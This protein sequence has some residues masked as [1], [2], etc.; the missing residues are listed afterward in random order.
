MYQSC[1]RPICTPTAR[2]GGRSATRLP[3]Y[4]PPD[5]NPPSPATVHGPSTESAIA[6][7]GSPSRNDLQHSHRA[8]CRYTALHTPM[9]DRSS[10]KQWRP[11]SKRRQARFVGSP[12]CTMHPPLPSALPKSAP[13]L[14]DSA[15]ETRLPRRSFVASSV[16]VRG[17]L[18]IGGCALNPIG[19]PAAVR[20]DFTPHVGL[21]RLYVLEPAAEHRSTLS[22]HCS[23]VCARTGRPLWTPGHPLGPNCTIGS[24][25][26]FPAH[27]DSPCMQALHLAEYGTTRR[28]VPVGF[29]HPRVPGRALPPRPARLLLRYG[30]SYCA[31]DSRSYR[32]WALWRRPVLA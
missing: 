14:P 27:P 16:E 13:R 32:V 4:P 6:I 18:G 24:R 28:V 11:A 25:E 19:N 30:T 17:P 22:L 5:P 26:C 29:C 3:T 20:D 7:V 8:P 10:A 9:A 12:S 31:R 23:V 2:R 21:G 1:T 15:R